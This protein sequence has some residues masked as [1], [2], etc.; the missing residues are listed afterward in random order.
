MKKHCLIRTIV[1]LAVALALC[2][3]LPGLGT[4]AAQKGGVVIEAMGTEPTNL[5]IFKAA[6]RPEYTILH[7]MFEPLFIVD[8]DL[9]VRPHLVES[10][11]VSADQK[12]WTF[13][14]KKGIKFH[15]GTPVNAEAVKFSFEK[16]IKGSQGRFLKILESVTVSDPM[17]VTM[18]LKK[19][20]AL[21]L[22]VLSS[23]NI[24]IASPTAFNKN[25]QEWGSK[26]MV[27]T[28]PMMFKEWRS[29]D[30]VVLVKSPDY[31][32]GPAFLTNK[33]PAYVDGWEI[34]FLPEP[35]T[36]IAELTAGAVDLS[37]Y[38][39]ERDVK[40]V[41]RS[42][43][44]ELIEAK[45]TSA[46]YLA[47]NTSKE[48]FNDKNI[49]I[50]AAHAVSGKA[51]RK[52]AMSGIG[53]PLYTPIS[54]MI[55][56]FY[57]PA[58]DVGKPLVS[59]DLEKAKQILEAAGWKDTNGDG[60]REKDG[61]ELFVNFLAFNIA[62]YKRMGE[63][64][65]PMLEAAGFKV[66]LQILEPGDL[67]QRTLAGKHNLL[68]TGLVG[69]QGYAVDDLV[70]ELH[71]GSLGT[72]AQWS[73]YKNDKADAMLDKARY[74]PDPK[75][76]EKALNEVQMIAAAE[77][78]VIPIANAMETFGFK[79]TLGGVENYVK[80]PWAFNQADEWRA[81]EIYKK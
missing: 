3:C 36:L 18:N 63:V 5:N 9:K 80:H 50:A 60:V 38:V 73:L 76:R 39:T 1:A 64:S 77:V 31:K 46:V 69:S 66:K 29:G 72:V 47:I 67:Y 33:G 56:G 49:R 8:P 20:Y 43:K 4:A 40:K 23:P 28:G 44:T 14:I 22:N 71:T 42:K 32:H 7:L 25:P 24:S 41:K 37:D 21:L 70:S 59:Y 48:P 79:K 58:E 15:D 45:S 74:N 11:K 52:G 53:A 81:L 12:T 34:R 30:R 78:V 68:A 35:T 61:K 2:V 16:H 10:Y 57:K 6:R 13:V 19:S 26:V 62:R 27:G 55:L 54:P 51:V 17:T 65:A 75:E